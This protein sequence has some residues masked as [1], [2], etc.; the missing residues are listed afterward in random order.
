MTNA[1]KKTITIFIAAI[2]LGGCSFLDV[3]P[4]G[5][6]FDNDMFT[7]AEGYEDAL[8]G[9]YAE[10][11]TVNG[12][13]SD[14]LYWIP[15]ALSANVS[16][17]DNGLQYMAMGQWSAFNASSIRTT[18]WKSAYS[19]INHVNNIIGHLEKGGENQFPHSRL[20]KG[21]ALA[22]RALIHFEMLRLF[23]AP[24]WASSADKARAIP[25]VDRYSF[26]IT[27]FSSVDEAYDKIIKDLEQAE[28]CLEEDGQLLQ[29]E[30]NN[31]SGGGFTS[32]RILHMNLYAVQALLAR[33]WWSRGD[34]DT[35][36]GY[37]SKVIES[38]KFTFRDKSAFVQYDNGTLDLKET[39]FGVYSTSSNEKN[40]KK[41]GLSSS[42]S[43]FI[44]ASDWKALYN[45]G[46]A[47]TGSDYRESAWFDGSR[48]R[49]LVNNSFI[50][51]TNS[52]SGPNILGINILRISEMYYILA[53]QLLSSDPDKATGVY[54]QA[55]ASRGLDKLSS[56]DKTL[57]ADI[58]FAERR[59]EFYGEGLH[60]HDCKRLGKD[61]KADATTILPGT[62]IN[63][64]RIPLPTSEESN[65]EER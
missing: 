47:L 15:E 59:K 11:G 46:S 24:V 56:L 10:L 27:A 49:V 40:A 13:Y 1:M 6:V 62:D 57:N 22:L 64:Y 65:R 23:G 21:E 8:Y 32:C 9:I 48:L 18:V 52:Y 34:L 5:E 60:W 55:I 33:V 36:A 2:M 63:T 38:G 61:I 4:K 20:Y 54:D 58:L 45:D 41:Y 25:Y 14:Y 51:G 37:A 44:L 50:E 39:I 12:L 43:S 19:T 29:A 7:S 42:G 28:L 17:S 16:I 30:R 26:S 31:A 53:E 3:N 35:A